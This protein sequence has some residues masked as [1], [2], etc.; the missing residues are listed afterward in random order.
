MIFMGLNR[1]PAIWQ[2]YINAT[3]DC[4]QSRRYCEATMDD[5]SLFTP[6]KKSH[7][8]KLKD[9]LKVLLKH[10]LSYRN[11]NIESTVVPQ[12]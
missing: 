7:K 12:N 1:S 9:L 11:A 6:D 3:L 5:L 8:A 4:L 2:A 10:S